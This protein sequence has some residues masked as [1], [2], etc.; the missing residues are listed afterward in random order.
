MAYNDTV[1]LINM[2]TK[3]FVDADVSYIKEF[4][5][6]NDFE[7][8]NVFEAIILNHDHISTSRIL[9]DILNFD[10]AMNQANTFLKNV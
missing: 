4:H 8:Q 5:Q 7:Q 9:N 3:C 2:S 1:S 10:H 6:L